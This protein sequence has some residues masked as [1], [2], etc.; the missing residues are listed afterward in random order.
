MSLPQP[1]PPI[2]VTL[3]EARRLSGFSHGA[4]Y[5]AMNRGVL[6][7]RK[8]LG[9]RLILYSS[10]VELLTSR[11]DARPPTSFVSRSGASPTDAAPGA[12]AR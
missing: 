8:V 1:S 2:T 12:R 4:L 9:R 6:E 5:D 3:K 7:S 10:L 11:A